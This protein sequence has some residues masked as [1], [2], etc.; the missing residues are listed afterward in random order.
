MIKIKQEE[1]CIECYK[2]VTNPICIDCLKRELISWLRDFEFN[3]RARQFVLDNLE[4][5]FSNYE[6]LIFDME[7]IMCGKHNVALC[8]SCFT[9]E[10]YRILKSL[11]VEKEVISSFL[12]L[13]TYWQSDKEFEREVEMM[14]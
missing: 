14:I 12:G 2:A 3:A 9:K 5:N 13:F 11:R 8:N 7:C 4:V 1:L 6:E 10:S